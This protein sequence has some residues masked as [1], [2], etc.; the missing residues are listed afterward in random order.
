MDPQLAARLDAV[1]AAHAAALTQ[2]AD[3]A[4]ASHQERYTEVARRLG[5]MPRNGRTHPAP[6]LVN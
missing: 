2:M 6:K 4:V 5:V 1:A 3:P